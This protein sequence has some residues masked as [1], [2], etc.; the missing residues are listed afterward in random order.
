MDTTPDPRNQT[1]QVLRAVLLGV[2]HESGDEMFYEYD[3]PYITASSNGRDKS[4][5][6]MLWEP[7]PPESPSSATGR[8]VEQVWPWALPLIHQALV[9]L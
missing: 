3:E 6:F 9:I 2:L 7:D 8:P 4:P 1:E 5:T